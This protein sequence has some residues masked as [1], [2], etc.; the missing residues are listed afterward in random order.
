VSTEAEREIERILR[1]E[2][3]LGSERAIPLDA[4]LGELGL[5]SLAII[6]LITAVENAYGVEIA[7]MVLTAETPPTLRD[8]SALVEGMPRAVSPA[9]RRGVDPQTLPPQG[10]LIELLE[11]ELAGRGLMR[12]TTWAALQVGWPWIAWAFTPPAKYIVLERLLDAPAI[13]RVRSTPGVE[14]RPYSPSDRSALAALWPPFLARTSGDKFDRW[15]RAGAS[16][17]VAA[18][19]GRIVGLNVLSITGEPGEV[20]VP[21]GRRAC[22]GIYLR[23]APNAR[24]RGIGLALLA[25][26]LADNRARGFSAQMSIVRT[27]NAPMLAAATQVLGFRPIGRA[28]RV[29]LAGLTRWSW[30]IRG[31]TGRGSRLVV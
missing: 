4:T 31:R 11:N 6:N 25:H 5:D 23:E 24:G 30:Q 17:T 14:L 28:T 2:I 22:W 16:A 1:Q 7:E 13:P 21:P 3:M 10:H 9:P 12:A 19:A 29:R 26:A 15:L 20:V 18:E 8:L 27:T